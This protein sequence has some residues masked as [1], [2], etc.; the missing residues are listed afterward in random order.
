MKFNPSDAQGEQ[1]VGVAK[2]LIARLGHIFR[3]QELNDTGIDAHVELVQQNTREVTGEIVALQLK[4]GQSYFKERTATGIVYRG[5]LPHLDYWLN[6]RLPVFVVLVETTQQR[7]YWQEITEATVERLDKGWKV[8]APFT[9]ALES[10]FIAA[11]RHRVG[12]EPASAY[13]TRLKL[14]D[15]SNG[16]TKRYAAHVLVR[17]PVTKLRLE[18]VVRRAS[19]EI[20]KETFHRTARLSEQFRDREADV[21]SLHLAADPTDAPNANWLCRTMWVNPNLPGDSRPHPIGGVDLGEGLEVI[22]KPDYASTGQFSKT[23]EMDKQTFLDQVRLVVAETER[24]VMQTFGSGDKCIVDD[25]TARNAVGAMRRIFLAS[26]DIGLGPYECR[27]VAERF[28]DVMTF[29]DNAFMAIDPKGDGG[30]LLVEL[31]LRDYRE[32]LGHLIYEIRKVV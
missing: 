12:L 7:A 2:T 28:Q 8:E 15:I 5:S 26:G 13:Y 6:H 17:H 25:V 30:Q 18:A 19:A 29:A 3:E 14:D 24:L 20:R 4:G 21:V 32:T 10:N 1:A 9:N 27:D 16:T 22:W 23:L 31:A 11:A